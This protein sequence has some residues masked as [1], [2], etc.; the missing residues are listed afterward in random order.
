MYLQAF[1][2][3]PDEEEV[4]LG[5]KYLGIWKEQGPSDEDAWRQLAHVLICTKEF[6]FVP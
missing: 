2:R 3:L 1:A 6:V 5:R 4:R